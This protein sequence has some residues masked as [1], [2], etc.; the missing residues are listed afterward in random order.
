[1]GRCGC[2]LPDSGLCGLS[3]GLSLF[4]D[5][6]LDFCELSLDGVADLHCLSLEYPLDAGLGTQ[7]SSLL[8]QGRFLHSIDLCSGLPQ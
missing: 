8:S 4:L 2:C 7:P 6:T 3:L 1:M 5:L